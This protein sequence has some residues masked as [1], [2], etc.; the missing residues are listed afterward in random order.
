MRPIF[1]LSV[2][3]SLFLTK[4]DTAWP[5]SAP[6]CLYS[7]IHLKGVPKKNSFLKAIKDFQM[8]IDNF[9]CR[10]KRCPFEQ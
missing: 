6:A 10:F 2:N 8:A 4:L 5:S 7:L 9:F 3:L 1:K